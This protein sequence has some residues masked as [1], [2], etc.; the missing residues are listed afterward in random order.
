M[1][2]GGTIPLLTPRL[3]LRRL[4]PEDVQMM[5]GNWAA[6]PAV[7]RWLRWQPHRDWT[8][9]ADFLAETARHYGE[10]D[11]YQ[12]GITERSTGIL[13]GSIC[14]MREEPDDGWTFD[15]APLGDAWAPGYCIGQKW[16]GR[17]YTT[18]ALCAVRDYW[19]GA[20][21]GRWLACCHANENVASGAVMQKA[22][23]TYDHDAA[24]HRF[25][26][27]PVPCRVYKLLREDWHGTNAD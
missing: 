6:D 19:F 20:V 3:A 10:P 5:F 16:W 14:L 13:F 4:T 9:S 2:H 12:W 1:N 11:W 27:S 22:G 18:E 26:G 23:F 15:A 17:G 8:V 25:D 24:Y 21:G 7:T